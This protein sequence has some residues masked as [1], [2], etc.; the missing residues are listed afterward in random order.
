MGGEQVGGWVGGEGG[1]EPL[2]NANPQV[3]AT[4]VTC[5]LAFPEN[6]RPIT[7]P[8]SYLLQP[9]PISYLLQPMPVSYLLQPVSCITCLLLSAPTAAPACPPACPRLVP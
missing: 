8:V 7:T 9:M 3:V 1:M 2:I 5:L 6:A 4:P